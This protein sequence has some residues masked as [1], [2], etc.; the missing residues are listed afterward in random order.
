MERPSDHAPDD[1]A[2]WRPGFNEY[3]LG[4]IV[5]LTMAGAA[6]GA[7]LYLLPG[8]YLETPEL[9]PAVR[10]ARQAEFPV[11]ASRVVN[12]GARIVLVVR[13]ADGEYTALQGTSPLDGCILEWDAVS[14]RIVS[15]CGYVVYDLH[16]NVVRGLTT[17]PLRPYAAF[18][19]QG[20]VYVT[21]P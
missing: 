9:Q 7:A 6:L 3:L 12:W 18:L 1:A 20:A 5:L 15:P 10:V 2:G 14:M 13:A 4:G 8:E 17:L 21:E 19:R 11:G 16:G